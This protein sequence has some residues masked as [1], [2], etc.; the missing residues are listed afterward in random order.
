[1]G[2][3]QSTEQVRT[4]VDMKMTNVVSNTLIKKNTTVD[5]SSTGNQIIRKVR[6][7][8]MPVGY[9]P[10]GTF[11]GGYNISNTKHLNMST[12][13]NMSNVNSQDITDAVK[14]ELEDQASAATK[15]DKSG[16]F[17][18][19]DKTT[20]SQKLSVTDITV[21]NIKQNIDMTLSTYMKQ[22]D[23]G[24]QIIEE[25]DMIPPC[26]TP[27]MAPLTLSNESYIDMMATDIA[28]SVTDV[29]MKSEEIKSFI[30]KTDSKLDNKN[31]DV[32]GQ[33]TDVANNLI[34]GVTTTATAGLMTYG[35]VIAVIVVAAILFI[36]LLIRAFS[37]GGG[38]GGGGGNRMRANVALRGNFNAGKIGGQLLKKAMRK[39]K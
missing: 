25:V 6:V 26:M 36:P 38:G 18:V 2:G 19:G 39:R 7:R 31:K 28:S 30:S 34:S 32:M 14:K 11:P 4:Y 3:E 17:A 37:G 15:N 13:V 21:K 16:T 24:D 1:M 12:V 8:T 27:G 35:I 29:V 5:Q 23:G 33:V 22:K 10:V 20:N 9:C